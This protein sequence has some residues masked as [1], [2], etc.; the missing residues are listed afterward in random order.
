MGQPL[1]LALRFQISVTIIRSVVW[2]Q[3]VLNRAIRRLAGPCRMFLSRFRRDLPSM[4]LEV[5]P[6]LSTS[7]ASG[8]SPPAVADGVLTRPS[9]APALK[10][11]FSCTVFS[12]NPGG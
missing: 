9:D 1:L 4:A 2:N 8:R 5:A 7:E 3:D 10:P 12:F 6:L 11:L